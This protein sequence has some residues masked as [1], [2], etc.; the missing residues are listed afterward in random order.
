[1]E[2]N[3]NFANKIW[4]MARFVL[5]NLDGEIT[6]P[7]ASGAGLAL[8]E[9]WI[10]ARLD[11][12]IADVTRLMDRYEFGQAGILA[13][14]FLWGDYADWYIEAAKVALAG[15][16]AA[17][18]AATR[19]VLVHVLDQGLRLLHPFVPF[20][21]E[22]VW[23]HLPRPAGGP[24]ALIVAPW[25]EAGAAGAEALARFDHLRDVVR[26][27]RNA[28]AENKVEQARRL[29][30]TVVAGERAEWLARERALL[31]AL[32]RLDEAHTRIV[33][34][35]PE[36]P[37]DAISLVIGATEVYLPLAGMVDQGAERARLSAALADLDR[38]IEKSEGLLRSEFAKK[39]PAAVVE[40]ERA[41]LAGLAESRQKVAERLAGT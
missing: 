39:A 2:A 22:E 16:D 6:A 32:A 38:Q 11:Q 19:G 7:A 10:M 40:K 23:Q 8:A 28:R 24:P 27:I 3:R 41:K 33:A 31:L 1:V 25:P 20:V 17:A 9:R 37:R 15:D 14:E 13:N 29:P 26:G 35:V 34:S 21:T 30:A 12:T 18:K 5:G 36:K 4:N